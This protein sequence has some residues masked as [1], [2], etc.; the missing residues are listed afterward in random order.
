MVLNAIFLVAEEKLEDFIKAIDKLKREYKPK[1][2][3]FECSGPWPPY[4]FI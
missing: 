2:F 4:N 1:G 3:D